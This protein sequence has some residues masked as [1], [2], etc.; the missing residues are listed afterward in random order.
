MPARDRLLQLDAYRQALEVACLPAAY[1][2]QA[3][4]AGIM[5]PLQQAMQQYTLP[6]GHLQDLLTA[7][8][9]DVEHTQ[10]AYVYADHAALLDYARYSA[11]PV[12]RLMLH[13]YGVDDAESLQQS[14]AICSALQLFNFWQDISVD[15]PRGRFY[16]PE[17]LCATRG[18]DP[19]R[20]HAAPASARAGLMEALLQEARSLMASGLTLPRTVAQKAGWLAGRELQLVMEGGLRIGEKTRALGAR[21]TAER[22]RIVWHDGLRMVWRSMR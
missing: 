21:I 16:L 19:R 18:V 20:P 2:E 17:D 4:W 12:G 13:L 7:F 5:Q 15:V 9:R 11:N 6:A 22:P 8:V 1:P 3:P 10:Q 14:D